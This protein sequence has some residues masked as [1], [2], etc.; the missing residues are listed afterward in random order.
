MEI[1]ATAKLVANF[2]KIWTKL[3]EDLVKLE[4]RENCHSGNKTNYKLS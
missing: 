3:V 1:S 2:H 4:Y